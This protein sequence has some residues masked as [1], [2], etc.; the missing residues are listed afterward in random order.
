MSKQ[1]QILR[2]TTEQNNQFTGAEGALTYDVE[3][4]ELRV[5]DGTTPGGTVVGGVMI[6]IEFQ[7]PTADNDYKWYIKYSNGWVEQGG[8]TAPLNNSRVSVT[9]PVQMASKDYSC[10]LT[11]VNKSNASA[12]AVF[13][14]YEQSSATEVCIATAADVGTGITWVIKGMAA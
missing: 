10:L 14:I 12:N 2:G 5:H 4:K 11:G 3:N 9:L 8:R 1:V 7:E 13:M 6:P